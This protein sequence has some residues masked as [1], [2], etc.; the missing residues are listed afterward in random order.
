MQGKEMM[1]KRIY[2]TVLGQIGEEELGH[3]QPHEHIYIV[4]TIDQEI[5]PLICMN[6]LPLSA[7]E[8]CLYHER[9]GDT[10]VDSNPLATGRDALALQ[11][12]SRLSGVNI[13][14]TTGYHIPKFYPA[15]HWIWTTPEEELTELFSSEITEGMY[16]GGSYV[17]PE[18]RTSVR[19]G[20]IKAVIT[21]EGLSDP[22]TVR[23]LTAAGK[24]SVRTGASIM[25][26]TD[27]VDELK[28]IDL[29]AGKIGVDTGSILVCHVDRQVEDLRIHEEIASTGVFMEYDTITLFQFHNNADEL[30]MLRHMADRGYIDQI[31]ISTDPETDRMKAYGGKVGI[32][33]ILEHFI[34]LM[35]LTGFSEDEITKI[36]RRNPAKA[37][38]VTER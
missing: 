3:C 9:G 34:P 14:A 37:L 12:I 25:I 2:Q 30:R 16:L 35:R 26:H 23:L 17:W 19:A 29:L 4:D 11:D 22:H 1:D 13:I 6:N 38:A 36:T 5:C 24:A 10:V 28:L 21:K 7:K 31:L 8:L 18:V 27:G 20:L 32:D 15:G 33:Y